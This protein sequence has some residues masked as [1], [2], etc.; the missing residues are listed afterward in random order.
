MR[1]NEWKCSETIKVNGILPQ[2]NKKKKKKKKKQKIHKIMIEINEAY[3]LDI[4]N[5][6]KY[7]RK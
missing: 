7:E 3:M 6:N 4:T 1:K 5:G 2:L